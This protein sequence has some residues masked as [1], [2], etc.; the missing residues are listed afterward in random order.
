MKKNLVSPI[1]LVQDTRED[2]WYTSGQYYSQVINIPFQILDFLKLT[3]LQ[4][5]PEIELHN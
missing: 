3:I 1:S 4:S 5:Y 2:L